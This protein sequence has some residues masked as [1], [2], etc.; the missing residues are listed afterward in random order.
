MWLV[1]GFLGA[2][3]IGVPIALLLARRAEP[4]L[5]PMPWHLGEMAK[6]HVVIMGTLAG[7]SITGLVLFVA[8]M[9]GQPGVPIAP[10]SAVIVLFVVS[11]IF[12]V[13][14]AFLLSYMPTQDATGE[15]I[16]RLHFSL[17]STIEYR[18]IF[19]SWF[20]MLP[21]L[22][23][24]DLSLPAS[25]LGLILPLSLLSGTLA[26]GMVSDG[27]G[28]MRFWE[29]Y[30]TM[31]IGLVLGLAFAALASRWPVQVRTAHATLIVCVLLFFV[32]GLGFLVVGSTPLAAR[33]PALRRLFDSNAR[34]LV[35][36]DMQLTAI[37]QIFLWLAVSGII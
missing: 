22:Q 18:T 10:L 23:A 33:Y 16:P 34:R 36:V 20:A 7:F 13:S 11:I 21:L 14:N 3:A 24:Y 2:I 31:A 29:T 27:T 17:C 1:A 15:I 12:Y 35:V 30:V 37:A 8:L 6:Q 26:I 19:I 25:V 28:L 4:F 32:N 5:G 9:R